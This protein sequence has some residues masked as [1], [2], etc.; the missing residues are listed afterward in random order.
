[1]VWD[2]D[3]KGYIHDV[4]GPT[5]NFRDTACDKQKTKGACPTKQCLWP[6]PCKNL[7][8][9]HEDYLSLLTKLRQLPNVKKVS[10]VQEFVMIISCMIKMIISLK[11]LF[12]IIFQDN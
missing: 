4:G 3:F 2:P 5:A 7:K 11:S 6:E 8:V 12:N 9:D 1:M 10:Y